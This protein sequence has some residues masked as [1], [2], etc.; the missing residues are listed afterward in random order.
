MTDSN[1]CIKSSEDYTP[2]TLASDCSEDK[3]SC[4]TGL[5]CAVDIDDGSENN[6]MSICI[7]WI[8][9]GM[10]GIYSSLERAINFF[11]FSTD[12]CIKSSEDYIDG[13][14]GSDCSLDKNGCDTGLV[15]ALDIDDGAGND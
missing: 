2:G 10:N 11:T 14:V 3:D 4:N 1:L 5:V 9:C 7:P 6:I 8:K 12:I 13:E 15:C